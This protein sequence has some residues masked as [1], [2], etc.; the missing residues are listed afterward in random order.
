[1]HYTDQIIAPPAGWVAEGKP[2]KGSEFYYISEDGTATV[3]PDEY[4]GWV[5]TSDV[6]CV[7]FWVATPAEGFDLHR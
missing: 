2:V 7:R 3:S 5:Y 4:D 6:H 1:M